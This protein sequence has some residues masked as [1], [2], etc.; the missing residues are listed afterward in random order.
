ML[1]VNYR[2]EYKETG[3]NEIPNY[4]DLNFEIYESINHEM[5]FKAK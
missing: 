5:N 1:C 3:S 2:N 4:I